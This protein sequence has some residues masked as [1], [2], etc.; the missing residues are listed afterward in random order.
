MDKHKLR[1]YFVYDEELGLL[2]WNI[3]KSGVPFGQVAG[4]ISEFNEGRRCVGID[5]KIYRHSRLVW[6][7]H[8][9]E[10]PDDLEI[11][12]R[13]RDPTNDRI[14]N[15]RIA[16]RQQNTRNR[17]YKKRDLPRGVQLHG[18]KFKVRYWNG[19]TNEYVGLFDSVEEADRAWKARATK[20]H[21]E[22]Y[23]EQ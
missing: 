9:G 4:C 23:L 20:E 8:H 3:R 21:G 7:Y 16:N 2:Y 14:E 15:L 18:R 11:D 6:V 1:E 13:D 10:L 5:N 12:H 17:K 19:E 22:F